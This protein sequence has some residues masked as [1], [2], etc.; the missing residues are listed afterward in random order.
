MGRLAMLCVLGALLY[1]YLSAGVHMFS[2]WR[3]SSHDRA[4]VVALKREHA[5]LLSQHETLSKQATLEGAARQLGMM[6]K[7]EQPYV[8][9]GLPAN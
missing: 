9:S 4:A 7:G 6:K 2:T 8:L 1:L 5:A 3:Q